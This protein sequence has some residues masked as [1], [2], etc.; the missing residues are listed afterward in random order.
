MPL[1][2]PSLTSRCLALLPG[3][4]KPPHKAHLQA[5]QYLLNRPEVDE[6]I[7][8]ISNRCRILPNTVLAIDAA[9]AQIIWRQFLIDE[10]RVTIEIA[11]HSAI[12]HALAYF[13][14]VDSHNS[15][16]FC[17]GETDYAAGDDRF[18]RVRALSRET[19][20]RAT[21][22]VVPA[23]TAGIGVRAT[24]IRGMLSRG[25]SGHQQFLECLPQHF[26][27]S[28][29]ELIWQTCQR[30]IRPVHEIFQEKLVDVLPAKFSLGDH[31][32]RTIEKHS[33]DPVFHLTTDN[34]TDLLVKY[35]GDTTGNGIFDD[36]LVPKPN[37]R[38]AVERRMLKHVSS[39]CSSE[40]E[41]PKPVHFDKRT[42]TLVVTHVCA[43]GH[44]LTEDLEQGHFDQ[45]I[46]AKI[47]TFLGILHAYP[48]PNEPLWGDERTEQCHW[49]AIIDRCNKSLEH[50]VHSTR[51]A[52]Q[53]WR[54]MLRHSVHETQRCIVHLS[55]CPTY[56]R[57]YNHR[58]GV[59][60]FERSS[61]YG[62][63]AYDLGTMIGHLVA[64][65]LHTAQATS[66]VNALEHLVE[67]YIHVVPG[68]TED[69][70]R[71]A[72]AFAATTLLARSPPSYSWHASHSELESVAIKVL[73]E[74]RHPR[75]D[76]CRL[77]YSAM[78]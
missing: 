39:C 8:I 17:I 16:V 9:A 6:V 34:G 53:G 65:G 43:G 75:I 74:L 4:F 12:E 47:G 44:P 2:E 26:N 62:D 46:A 61:S 35:A 71:R 70:I 5:V 3:S 76:P 51:E 14:R 67:A 72:I 27:T 19:G 66:C 20:V 68:K 25:E 32:F 41:L 11:Q 50:C 57:V 13:Y 22:V 56:L 77:M 29:R 45:N 59:T 7:I 37:R 60:Q 24:E 54:Q 63:P 52:R 15:L 55:F 38:L 40:F 42:R 36:P 48:L 30:Q 10:P 18:G 33:V 78:V 21:V 28:H 49:Q 58:I 64:Y 69:R 23:R 73:A 1:S 31:R